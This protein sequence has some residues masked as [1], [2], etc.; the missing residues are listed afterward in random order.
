[1]S[2]NEVQHKEKNIP[3]PNCGSLRCFQSYTEPET[4][5]SFMCVQCGYMSHSKYVKGSDIL[6]Q[7]LNNSAD[8][9]GKLKLEDKERNIVWLPSVLNMGDRGII[10]PEGTSADDWVWKYAKVKKLE[11]SERKNY[12]VPNKTDEYYESILEVKE[13]K[14]Y[15]RLD[16]FGACKD[17]GI[18]KESLEEETKS[19]GV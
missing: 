14:V 11:E 3:C 2:D 19:D 15:D 5:E 7:Q 18:I 6:N 9:V 12:P 4:D 10:Y 17:M 16:F 13:A 8:L 1:M